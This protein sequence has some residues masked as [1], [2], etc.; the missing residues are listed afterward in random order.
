MNQACFELSDDAKKIPLFAEEWIC[1]KWSVQT[2]IRMHVCN[3]VTLVWDSLRLALINCWSYP[4]ACIASC[5]VDQTP[6]HCIYIFGALLLSM[7]VHSMLVM[8]RHLVR[9]NISYCERW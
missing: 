2:S 6:K 3:E 1:S 4:P 8:T 9:T 5:T 7:N